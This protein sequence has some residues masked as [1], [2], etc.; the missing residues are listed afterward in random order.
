MEVICLNKGSYIPYEVIGSTIN[1]NGELLLD[2]ETFQRD[3]IVKIDVCRDDS[4]GALV[5][6]VPESGR[7]VAQIE[8]YAK[9]YDEVE[10]CS[11]EEDMVDGNV[12]FVP[13]E[14]DISQCFLYLWTV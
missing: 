6:A 8:I 9:E 1:F 14:F 7:Y 13:R 5:S 12:S 3:D 11:V 10:L 4:T 2:L